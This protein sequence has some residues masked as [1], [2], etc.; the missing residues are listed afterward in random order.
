MTTLTQAPKRPDHIRVYE[1]DFFRIRE[2]FSALSHF[3]GF[4]LSIFLLPVLLIRASSF[5]A[6]EASLSALAV[7]MITMILLYGASASYHAF[8]ISS[9]ANRILKKIDHMSV[10]VLI[11]GS[12]TPI[13]VSA[14]KGNGGEI[15]LRVIWGICLLG[16]FFKAFFVYCPR[17]VSSVIYVGMGWAA[18]SVFPQL[19]HVLPQGAFLLLLSGG[20]LYT[21]GA[22]IYALKLSVFTNEI[23][24]NHELFHLFVL[25]GSA[26][27]YLMMFLY[28]AKM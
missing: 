12:Y 4:L 1:D 20:L 9:R 27:H 22:V 10:F 6:S 24:G 16:I 18:L 25:A 19:L 11:A 23:F 3:A 14:L 28:I 26:C 15:L 21:I 8:N 13:C 7:Y 5:S 17:W 2:P